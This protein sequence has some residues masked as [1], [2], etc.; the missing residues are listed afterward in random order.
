MFLAVLVRRCQGN[1]RIRNARVEPE[2][3]EHLTA[4]PTREQLLS[5]VARMGMKLRDLLRERDAPF[6]T[7]GLDDTCLIDAQILDATMAH[8]ILINRPIVVAPAGVRHCRPAETVIDLSLLHQVA[9]LALEAITGD[10]AGRSAAE[11]RTILDILSPHASAA[12]PIS[13]WQDHLRRAAA[14]LHK[15]LMDAKLVNTFR[16]EDVLSDILAPNLPAMPVAHGTSD[17]D[18]C[19][20]ALSYALRLATSLEARGD[21][22]SVTR[23]LA[24]MSAPLV[25][26]FCA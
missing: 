18:L 19:R 20:D 13:R 1:G 7:F 11:A 14:E 16:R 5:P 12:T 23:A 21:G 8:P 22:E 2:I 25:R 9:V 10:L 15:R 6:A 24:K 4:P 26:R 17:A 3:V